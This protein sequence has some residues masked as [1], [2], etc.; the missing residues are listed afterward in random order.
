VHVVHTPPPGPRV[1]THRDPARPVAPFVD[2]TGDFSLGLT[3]GS[4]FSG[5]ESGA[6]YG[7]FG[8][9]LVGRYRLAQPVGLEVAWSHY[10]DAAGE[11]ATSPLA[12][13]VQG[14]G[15]PNSPVN[16]YALLGV[17]F[18]GRSI[19]DTF[20]EG[21]DL[22][23]LTVDDTLFGPHAGLGLEIA[24]G[25]SAALDLEGR[26][27]SYLDVAPEDPT[28]PAAIQARVGFNWYF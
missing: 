26:V 24:L 20:C 27:T 11:R 6:S 9:G 15:F 2:R 3:G 8:L 22:T 25:K 5:Y 18:T 16:P 1:V 23:T 4:Y 13:S 14:F 17:T 10:R 19:D 7:D 12:L 21:T 28:V